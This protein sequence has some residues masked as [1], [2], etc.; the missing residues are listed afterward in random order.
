[1]FAISLTFLGM[2]FIRYHLS[3]DIPCHRPI[4]V[5]GI[6][7][8]DII[9][10][11]CIRINPHPPDHSIYVVAFFFIQFAYNRR[12]NRSCHRVLASTPPT[13]TFSSTGKWRAISCT[14]DNFFK[15]S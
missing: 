15:F 10:N 1:M 3:T 13:S 7:F 6:F 14:D 12:R 2:I 11:R 5:D 8:M 9:L 4:N